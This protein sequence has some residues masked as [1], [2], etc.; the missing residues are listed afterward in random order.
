VLSWFALSH[1]QALHLDNDPNARR[2]CEV[3]TMERWE[4]SQATGVSHF[5]TGILIPWRSMGNNSRPALRPM[6]SEAE[7]AGHL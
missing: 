1:Q 4:T 6:A 2:L 7:R 5:H 3:K